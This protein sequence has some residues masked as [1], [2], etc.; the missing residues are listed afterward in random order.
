[1]SSEQVLIEALE[2]LVEQMAKNPEAPECERAWGRANV[3]LKATKR[4]GRPHM[5]DCGVHNAPALKATPCDCGADLF[6]MRA[7]LQF[8]ATANLEEEKPD[9][10]FMVSMLQDHARKALRD[11]E[12]T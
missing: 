7:A 1:M 3:V 9:P 5:S 2:E 10:Q 4:G 11:S 6:N 12:A 8:I